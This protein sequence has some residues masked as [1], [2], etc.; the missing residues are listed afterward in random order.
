MAESAFR[1]SATIDKTLF[2][3]LNRFAEDVCPPTAYYPQVNFILLI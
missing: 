2:F 1:D 3:E